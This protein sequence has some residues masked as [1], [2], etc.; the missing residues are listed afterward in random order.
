MGQM[1]GSVELV[2][3]PDHQVTLDDVESRAEVHKEDPGEGTWGIQVL[4]EEVQRA[5]HSILCAPLG[6]VGNLD[7]V[8]LLVD[9]WQ[10]GVCSSSFSS[11]ETKHKQECSCTYLHVM[12]AAPAYF[13]KHFLH[14]T[15]AAF[16]FKG[17][18]CVC[19]CVC[20]CLTLCVCV[21]VCVCLSDS[22]CVCV[23]LS[24]SVCVCVC[25]RVCSWMLEWEE[26]KICSILPIRTGLRQYLVTP[27]YHTY[28]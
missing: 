19:V 5:G 20:V 1:T 28:A 26:E 16:I 8:Q 18:V 2:Y 12:I 3:R 7:G 27:L 13:C 22:V 15:N 4:E 25:V 17:C 9:N 23:C 21:C 6:P 11:S 24:D 14:Q 10:N